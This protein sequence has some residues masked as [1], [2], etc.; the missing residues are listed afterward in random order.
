MFKVVDVK[1]LNFDGVAIA[2]DSLPQ[3]LQDYVEHFNVLNRKESALR[4]D[5]FTIEAA[6][7]QIQRDIQ[8]LWNQ[9]QAKVAAAAKAKADAEAAAKTSDVAPPL[10]PEA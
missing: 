9:E 10:P 1:V 5:L 8:T 6:K 4:S 3:Q 2:V 7:L